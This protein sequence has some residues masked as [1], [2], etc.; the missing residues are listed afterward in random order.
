VRALPAERGIAQQ[1]LANLAGIR[2]SH[3]GKIE[4][5]EHVPTR[6]IIFSNIYRVRHLWMR[7]NSVTTK[8]G[9]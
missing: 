5:G 1:S 2:R 4:R 8:E 9:R 7:F 3:V 6:A